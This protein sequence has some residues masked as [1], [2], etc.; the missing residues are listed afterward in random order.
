MLGRR[1]PVG[2]DSLDMVRVRVAAPAAHEPLGD[3]RRPVD[4]LLRHHRQTQPACRLGDERQRHHRRTGQV[5]ADLRVV[6]VEQLLEPPEGS[7]HRERALHVDADVAG[8]HRDRERLG[9]GQSRVERAVDQQT[10]HVAVVVGADELFDVDAA[11]AQRSA[12]AV[13]LGDLGLE[14]NDTFEAVL[15]YLFTHGRTPTMCCCPVAML[16]A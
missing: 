15:N 4:V 12:L 7:Q 11:V 5:V 10:P 16:T 3:G 2:V 9:G 6:D 14:G 13:G 1:H 8:V